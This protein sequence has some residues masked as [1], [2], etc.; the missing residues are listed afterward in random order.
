MAEAE[1]LADIAS[2]LQQAHPA[3]K[4]SN[5][6]K[7]AGKSIETQAIASHVD[8]AKVESLTDLLLLY[9]QQAPERKHIYFQ[10]EDGNEE[11]LTY[12]DL[13]QQALIVAHALQQRG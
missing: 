3:A 13:L 6:E 7:K 9:A 11:I 4:T 2:Y 10:N 8:P 12:G 1:T 5:F